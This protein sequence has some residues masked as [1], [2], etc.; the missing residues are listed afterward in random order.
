MKR[1]PL[2]LTFPSSFTR[3][4]CCLLLLLVSVVPCHD[5]RQSHRHGTSL[6]RGEAADATPDCTT[7]DDQANSPGLRRQMLDNLGA[8]AWHRQGFRGAGVKVAI[9]D[10]GFCGY[11]AHLGKALPAQVTVHSFREDGNLEARDSQHGI[12]CGEVIRALAPEAEL[13]LANWETDRPES[14]LAAVRW[15]R[16]QGA[17]VI[18]CSVIMPTWSDGEGHGSAHQKLTEL[19]GSGTQTQDVLL[20]ASAG[21]TAQ[22]HWGGMFHEASP[23]LHDW[24]LGQTEN[25][26]H[27]WGTD[28]VSVEL[29]WPRGARYE[30]EVEDVTAGRLA[31]R[32]LTHE[33]G[34][35]NSAVVRFAPQ[36]GH[37]YTLKLR[38]R[39]GDAS[40]FHLVVLGGNLDYAT[41][42]GS[43]PFPADGS[44]VVAVGAVNRAGK[45]VSYS[46]CGESVEHLKPDLAATIPFPS[47]WRERPFTGTSAAAP[48]AAGLAALVLSRHPD[49]NADKV[50]HTLQESVKHLGNTSPNCETG[51]GQIHLP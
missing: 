31:G 2:S 44:E 14:F 5:S 21:N 30:L 34:D 11:R 17:R 29:C 18:S 16:K 24:Q 33:N 25:V 40:K 3:C 46:S 20:F 10:T 41:A 1:I 4:G 26:I 8:L 6:G 51:Y 50:R 7:A 48:Q 13:L 36:Q 9:L 49:W 12:L 38:K 32:C 15:A 47:T 19:L 45:R 43:V 28:R 37:G 22:R 27:P 35:F 42:S 23:G 39:S